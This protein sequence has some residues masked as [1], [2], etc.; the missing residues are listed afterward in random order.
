MQFQIK[1][2]LIGLV[3]VFATGL[4]ILVQAEVKI[5]L[6]T[7][8]G[9]IYLSLDDQRAP[10]TVKNFVRY[11]QE[12]FYHDTVFHRVIDGFMIQG[13]GMDASLKKKDTH[14]NIINEGNNGLKNER[15]TV[16][17]ARMMEPDTANAQFFINL[18]DNS[19]LNPHARSA[20]YAVFG[21]VSRGMD[22]VDKIAKANTRALNGHENVPIKP[23]V[24]KAVSV[25][26]EIPASE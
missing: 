13:G 2:I 1:K 21:K 14:E 4:P 17:M 24:I 8:E 12:G 7:S 19:F 10:V 18:V 6:S 16:A 9:D 20:G 25:I 3:I 22:V 15:G 5:L 26:N 11:A 23:V